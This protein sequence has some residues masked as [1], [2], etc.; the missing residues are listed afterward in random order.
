MTKLD[1]VASDRDLWDS[2]ARLTGVKRYEVLISLDKLLAFFKGKK[3]IIDV[4]FVWTYECC[5]KIPEEAHLSV[6]YCPI[7]GGR[8]ERI[9]VKA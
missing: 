7:H 1:Y 2:Y 9:E 4:N 6:P 5:D 8:L 3:E